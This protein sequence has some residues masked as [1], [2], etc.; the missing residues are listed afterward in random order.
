M[1]SSSSRMRG[2][3]RQRLGELEA[4]A[5]GQGQAGGAPGGERAEAE[6]LDDLAGMRARVGDAMP[7]QQ[8]PDQHVL[9]D[10]QLGERLTSWKVAREAGGAHLVGRKPEKVAPGQHGAPGIGASAPAIR[11]KVVVLPAPLGPMSAT[12]RPSGTANDTSFTRLQAAEAFREPLDRQQ[13]GHERGS[14]SRSSP[15]RRASHGQD[16]VGQETPRSRT[17]SAP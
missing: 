3:V 11:L 17:I 9:L 14:A 6:Q 7:A 16:A 4:L 12:M 8:R 15:R 1:T 5:V 13:V 10:R 2:S